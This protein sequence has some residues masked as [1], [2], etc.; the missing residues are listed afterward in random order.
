M[1]AFRVRPK[2]PLLLLSI[3]CGGALTIFTQASTAHRRHSLAHNELRAVL[4]GQSTS[5]AWCNA[6]CD[7][8]QSDDCRFYRNQ[9]AKVGIQ[10]GPQVDGQTQWVANDYA[11][12]IC[13]NN[14][15]GETCSTSAPLTSV[16]CSS[17]TYCVCAVVNGVADCTVNTT[18]YNCQTAPSDPT[19]CTFSTYGCSH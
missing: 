9:C 8:G 15:G 12:E 2:L 17:E 5:Q 13:D 1:F 6:I 3:L 14:F 10:C 11:P 19:L 18:V 4:G 16:L 7:G